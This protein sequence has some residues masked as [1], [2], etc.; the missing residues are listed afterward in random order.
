MRLTFR[1]IITD[2]QIIVTVIMLLC[3]WKWGDWRN[4]K[5]YY[6]TMLFFT[7]GDFAYG[8]LTYNYPLWE[9]ESPLLKTTLSDFLISLVF[10]PATLLIYLPHFPEK[11]KH[12]IPYVLLWVAIYTLIERV[13][14]LTGFF[15]Y[16]NGWTIWLSLIFNG[17]MFPLL[18]LHHKKP[19]LALLAAFTGGTLLMFYFKVPLI[20]MK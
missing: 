20:S 8:L 13:S 17:I 9:F 7:L 6:P 1:S 5:K 14:F 12:K 11:L 18:A 15:S 19:L 4:W 2:Y 10:F 3:A 16:H